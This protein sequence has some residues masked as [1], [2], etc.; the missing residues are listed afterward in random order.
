MNI[1]TNSFEKYSCNLAIYQILYVFLI[2]SFLLII[3]FFLFYFEN[4]IVITHKGK[5]LDTNYLEIN[6]LNTSDISL[7]LN[8]KEI[9]IDDKLISKERINILENNENYSLKIDVSNLEVNKNNLEIKCIIKKE[10]LYKFIFRKMKG[11]S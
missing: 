11:E 9:K 4:S 8:S 2:I 1:K 7:I 10:K 3:I 6:D 5:I